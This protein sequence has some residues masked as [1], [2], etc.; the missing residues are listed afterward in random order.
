L[1]E[2]LFASLEAGFERA[3]RVGP[4]REQIVALAGAPV[5]V[6][7]VG[8][9]LAEALARPFAHLVT[10]PEAP[11]L[12]IA[13]WDAGETGV[14]PPPRPTP[15]APAPDGSLES[16][17]DGRFLIHARPGSVVALDRSGGRLVGCVDSASGLGLI[18][19]ARPVNVALTVWCA[20]REMSLVHAGLVAAEGHG[21]LIAGA[22]GSGKSSTALACA[23]AGFEFL[24][25]DTVALGVA[26]EG[27]PEGHSLYNS[28]TVEAGHLRGFPP[29][30][31]RAAESV[32][33]EKS[34]VFL[35]EAQ[36]LRMGRVTPISAIVLPVVAGS[37]QAPVSRVSGGEGLLRLG[38]SSLIRRAL[39]P[40]ASLARMA[41]L[42]ERV[43]SYRLELDGDLA[44]IPARVES[45]LAQ[46]EV[47]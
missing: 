18:D 4:A 2:A 41:A 21:V 27:E 40:R 7:A 47:R 42:V 43:P 33:G 32:A 31:S 34:V 36:P 38:P 16:S 25:D 15:G 3:R 44:G 13:L 35:S 45:V 9:D 22:S 39:P 23:C 1:T 46:A 30:V 11:E 20:D 19:R 5:R 12:T 24:G 8:S 6:E 37:A 14:E 29:V 28:V 17:A 26:P 10:V